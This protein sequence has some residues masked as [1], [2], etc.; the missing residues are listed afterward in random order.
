VECLRAVIERLLAAPRPGGVGPQAA[1]GLQ[2]VA[3]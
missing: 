2:A 3:R 1:V